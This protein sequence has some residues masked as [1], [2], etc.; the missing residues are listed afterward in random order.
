MSDKFSTK[1]ITPFQNSKKELV[2]LIDE[3][4]KHFKGRKKD[5]KNLRM[6][7]SGE[8]QAIATLYKEKDVKVEHVPPDAPKLNNMVEFGFAIRSETSKTLMQNSGI[9]PS[10]KKNNK[11][12]VKEKFNACFLNE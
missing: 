8:N 1:I 4:F 11:I 10:A 7:N 3:T 12:I 5:V 6:E 9:K 2:V